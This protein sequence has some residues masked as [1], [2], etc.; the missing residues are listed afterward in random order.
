MN[1]KVYIRSCE[2]D[3][4]LAVLCHDSWRLNGF[5]GDILHITNGDYPSKLSIQRHIVT[6]EIGSNYGG[7]QGAKAVVK[8]IQD[9]IDPTHGAIICDADIIILSDF[10][11]YLPCDDHMGRGG[12][13][14][15]VLM[16]S[17]QMQILSPAFIAK[18]NELTQGQV[19]DIVF[20]QMVPEGH[21]IA[22]DSFLSFYSHKLGLEKKLIT[23]QGR[24]LHEK[25]Y[26]K[27]LNEI[28]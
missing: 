15:D 24:W 27:T 22:D 3:D 1:Y 6:G 13:V 2:R 9:Y 7:Q 10:W 12:Y 16:L 18:I 23:E 8:L 19:H 5:T 21:H 25:F 14:N 20:G 26:G 28:L 11:K 4:E 17:G